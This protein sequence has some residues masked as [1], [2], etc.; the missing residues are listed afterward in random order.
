MILDDDTPSL[1]EYVQKYLSYDPNTGLVTN[2]LRNFGPNPTQRQKQWLTMYAKNPNYALGFLNNGYWRISLPNKKH[3]YIHQ[4]AF[5]LMIGSIPIEVDHKD[6]NKENNKFD[7]L[8]PADRTGNCCNS[9]K[10]TTN[11]SGLK[12]VSWAAASYC[13][14]MDIR[15]NQV[16]YYSFYKTKELAYEA[17]CKASAELHGEFGNVQ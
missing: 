2:K 14:R 9:S 8:R 7:N 11:K 13:W 6:T 5:L 3:L 1:R 17:Y 15:Y 16:R 4:I 12:G 10:R